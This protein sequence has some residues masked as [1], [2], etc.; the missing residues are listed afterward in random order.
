[1][2]LEILSLIEYFSL[3]IKDYAFKGVKNFI[4]KRILDKK[5]TFKACEKPDWYTEFRAI[6]HK[7]HELNFHTCKIRIISAVSIVCLY[8]V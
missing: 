4:H 5:C 1:M 2:S 8:V 3:R 6:S 7:S